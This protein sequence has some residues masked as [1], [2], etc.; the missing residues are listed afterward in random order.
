MAVDPT[1]ERDRER[2]RI[3][4]LCAPFA[5]L[6]VVAGVYPLAEVVR[7][8]VSVD[9]YQSVGFSLQAYETLAS[10]PY[11]RGIAVNSLWLSGATTLASVGLAIPIAHA[12]EKYD[13]PGESLLVTLVSFPISLPGIVAAFMI[14]VTLGNNGLVTNIVA[15]VTGRD[16]IDLAIAVS[17]P[18]LFV[19]FCYSMIPRATLI[20]RGTYAEIDHA[21]EEAAQSLGATPWQTFRHVTFPQIRPGI[22][23]ALI[24]TFRT[25][26]AIFGTLIIIQ[27]VVVWTLQIARELG[28]GYTIQVAGAM[29]TIYFAFTFAFTA[30]GLRYTDA[31]VGL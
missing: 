17:T 13:L 23:G 26:L 12:L 8:S 22:T 28:S 30:L 9:Q 25:G 11:Y 7:I 27:A 16:A 5:T 1:T 15:M 4:I 2:R 21:A 24:L 18:G 20:L 6:L 10:D 29:A 3:V 19:A 31:E 14:L